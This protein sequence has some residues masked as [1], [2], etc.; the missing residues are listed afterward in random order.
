MFIKFRF[1]TEKRNAIAINYIN[2]N[3]INIDFIMRLIFFV[4]IIKVLLNEFRLINLFFFII[5][6]LIIKLIFVIIIDLIINNLIFMI[7]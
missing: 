1:R 6:N 5:L 2:I 4:I 3:E 7:C